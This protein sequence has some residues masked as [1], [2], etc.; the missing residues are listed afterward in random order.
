MF[1]KAIAIGK[2]KVT[3]F[4]DPG[5]EDNTVLHSSIASD[6]NKEYLTVVF[7]Y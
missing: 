6:N 2:I 7:K 3:R 4:M 5:V 1:H